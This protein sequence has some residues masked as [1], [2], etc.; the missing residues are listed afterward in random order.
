M[1]HDTTTEFPISEKEL[2][3]L[4]KGLPNTRI[5]RSFDGIRQA[6]DEQYGELPS[7]SAMIKQCKEWEIHPRKISYFQNPAAFLNHDS[8][9]ALS[10]H[11]GQD[12]VIVALEH[13]NSMIVGFAMKAEEIIAGLKDDDIYTALKLAE[14][15]EKALA[16][17]TDIRHKLIDTLELEERK[18][19]PVAVHSDNV[20]DFSAFREAAR[21]KRETPVESTNGSGNGT[22]KARR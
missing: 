16:A 5:E 6:I 7:R 18:A 17:T 11:K 8:K 4:I 15:A 1:Q 13:V 2:L 9:L 14:H 12:M 10:K 20:D 3:K 22:K 21:V 19:K